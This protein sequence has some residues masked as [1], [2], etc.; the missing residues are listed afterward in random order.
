MT[1]QLFTKESDSP[2][3]T[4][5]R[6]KISNHYSLFIEQPQPL[7]QCL[8]KIAALVGNMYN[9]LLRIP[10]KC[11]PHIFHWI[12]LE[13]NIWNLLGGIFSIRPQIKNRPETQV[14]PALFRLLVQLDRK[15]NNE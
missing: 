5:T 10:K 2:I 13:K 1:N 12:I 3:V 9:V 8:G 14:E 6:M 7:P 11:D 15:P 4:T